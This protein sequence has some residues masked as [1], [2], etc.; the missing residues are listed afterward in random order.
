MEEARALP[1]ERPAAWRRALGWAFVAGT[2][3][4]AAGVLLQAFSIAADI[5]GAG[6]SALDLH[7][8]GG[9]ITHSIE[10]VTLLLAIAAFWGAWRFVGYAALLPI[11]G[12]AQL[13]LVG[14]T[15]EQGGWVNGLHGLLALVV[16]VL[17]LWLA[18]GAR[19]RLGGALLRD[20][21]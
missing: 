19:R 2:A 21:V 15:E 11:I 5:R 16:F 13:V 6:K 10:V 1:D 12:T 18:D 20:R 9:F 3:V 7:E 17:A 14:D 8:T 4:V